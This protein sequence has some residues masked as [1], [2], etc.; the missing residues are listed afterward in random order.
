V[1]DGGALANTAI[2]VAAGATFIEDSASAITGTAS[3]T[4]ADGGNVTLAAPNSF[5]GGVTIGV[6]G[7]GA[8]TG[9]VLAEATQALGAGLVNIGLNGN[10]ATGI[11]QLY[12]GISLNNAITF[13]G[14]TSAALG[15]ENIDGNNTL[16]GA[17]STTVGG[18]SYVIQSDAGTLSLTNNAGIAIPS[19]KTLTL[20]G[21]GNGIISG[22]LTSA[23][24]LTKSGGGA[25]TLSGADSYTGP[26]NVLG[27]ILEIAGTAS[28]T[29]S[30]TVGNGASL[31]LAGGALSVSGP[32]TNDGIFK[33][34]GTAALA[35]TGAFVNNGVLDLINGPRTLPA[36]F[37][38]NGTVLAAGSVQVQ[39]FAMSGSTLT[40][41]IQGYAEH[42]YQLQRAS[43]LAPPVTWAN[44]GAPQTGAGAPLIFTDPAGAA[45]SAGFYQIQIS[46]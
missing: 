7:T 45:G 38:N 4:A 1:L 37:T 36:S 8:L 33:L 43:S 6:N 34:S 26:T 22:P 42:T 3:L 9:A 16:S 30:L 11:L 12:G 10:S 20:Q 5:S 24:G 14:R 44:V 35:Q 18:A 2:S 40:L 27:G 46:P 23:G 19:G 17:I 28:G 29:S 31:Y 25:W 21:A 41:T 32:I 15:I 39:Q 13:W